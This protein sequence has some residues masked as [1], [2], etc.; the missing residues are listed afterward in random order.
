MAPILVTFGDN[1]FLVVGLLAALP[2]LSAEL[3]VVLNC[4]PLRETQT[5]ASR[6]P[7]LWP[8]LVQSWGGLCFSL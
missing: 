7:R 1:T 4:S 2:G 3:S 5:P 6:H 8:P